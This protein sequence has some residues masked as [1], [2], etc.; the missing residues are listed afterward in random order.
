M[1]ARGLRLL[2][3]VIS[4]EPGAPAVDARSVSLEIRFDEAAETSATKS[5][6]PAAVP[7]GRAYFEALRPFVARGAGFEAPV[8][9]GSYLIITAPEFLESVMPL[10]VWKREKGLQVSV[11]TTTETGADRGQIQAY[12]RNLYQTSATPPEYVLLVGDVEQL[13]AFDLDGN[14]SDLPYTLMDVADFVPDILVGRLSAQNVPQAQTL[15]AKILG[16]E[17]T[18]ALADSGQWMG[19]GLVVGGNYGSETPVPVSR[20]CRQQMLETGLARV[21]SVYFPPFYQSGTPRI[22]NFVGRGLSMV[23]YRGWARGPDGWEAPTFLTT[24]V[25][26]LTN[27][28]KLP[29]VFS[30]VCLNNRFDENECF[31]ESWVRAGTAADPRGAVAFIGNG[32]HWSHTRFND[33]VAIGAF[34]GIRRD[35]LRKLGEILIAGKLNLL[36]QFP[37]EIP[38]ATEAR[39]SV[40]FYFYIYNLLGDPEMEI[41]TG[42]ARAI[43]VTYRNPISVGSNFIAVTVADTSGV[44]VA[45][46]R[47]G[48]SQ[49]G[50]RLGSAWTDESGV[51]HVE[52]TLDDPSLPL[53]IVVTG[54]NVVPFRG[55]AVV[56]TDTPSLSLSGVVVDDDGSGASQGNGDGLLNPA[57]LAEIAVTLYNGGPDAIVGGLA[58][59]FAPAGA[60][61]VQGDV[62]IG[63]IPVGGS[64]TTETPFVVRVDPRAEDGLV[65]RFGLRANGGVD[66]TDSDVRL[67]VHAPAL[68]HERAV[69]GGDGVLAAGESAEL[70]LTI[71]NDG[72]VSASAVTAVLRSRDLTL[73]TVADSTSTFGVVLPGGS[74]AAETPFAVTAAEGAPAGQAAPLVLILAD[75]SGAVCETD[76]SVMIGEADA[77]A[78]LGPDDYGY[79]AY[80]CT[81]TEYPAGVP[82]YDWVTCSTLF[83]GSGTRLEIADNK[84]VAVDLPF[85]FVYYGRSYSRILVSDNGW[86]SFDLATSFDYYNW[87]MPNTY[88]SAAVVAAF[89]DNLDPVKK[90][91]GNSDS[92]AP[93]AGDGIYTYY[94]ATRDL[95]AIEW[96]RQ[97]NADQPATPPAEP[98]R[99]DDLQT[100][101][102]LLFDPARHSTPTGDGIIQ[103]QYK[104][105]ANVDQ[106]RM[107]STVGIENDTEDDGIEYTYSNQYPP[108]ASSLSSGLAIR[109]TTAPPVYEP[110]RLAEFRSEPA[111]RGVMLSW[112]PGRNRNVSGYRF[113]RRL[114]GGAIGRVGAVD[115]GARGFLDSSASPDSSQEYEVGILDGLMRE[116]RV[117]PFRYEGRPQAPRVLELRAV[118][119]MPSRG[120]IEFRASLPLAG[121]ASL[122]VFDV[123]GR[124]VWSSGRAS[125]DAGLWSV[126]WS[127]T[128]GGGRRV[129]AGIYLARVEAGGAARTVKAVLIR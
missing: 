15:V 75:A 53:T 55:S 20:W 123:T 105:I 115:G 56:P 86:I 100:F 62:L 65:L 5:G 121:P 19:R 73:V 81:D 118:N 14:V 64:A 58:A 129:P 106:G 102:I 54:Q 31:G 57:E 84:Q 82:V 122:R 78:P 33:A 27:G 39:E 124:L 50:E 79:W 127:G 93:L 23:T 128:D 108:A 116:T 40:E 60:T 49:A 126:R 110:F 11:V 74:A 85:S 95:F 120:G 91:N 35:G 114:P 119:T 66:F 36:Q 107:Y 109:F 77:T 92:D 32:E 8:A 29:V 44:P 71:V 67:T 30:F 3:V 9:E 21:D 63:A 2:P 24:H 17:S 89:W 68:R 38:Y 103:F 34:T 90:L 99:F 42:P 69:I 111:A 46:A 6:S 97:G 45:G 41:W 52:M 22:T 113:Y 47:V 101:E 37:L 117:G 98:V 12:I 4:R 26:G 13:P 80:D 104:Q 7:T 125:G 94:D 51:A 16:F 10:A 43:D 76:F 72:S 112:Q 88:G 87:A 25:A 59:L 61:I 70:A 48:V 96:S 18:P 83:G 28:W 1:T